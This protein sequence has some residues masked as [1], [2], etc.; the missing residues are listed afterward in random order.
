MFM[1]SMPGK[2]PVGV[3]DLVTAY[4]LLLH[5]L[6]DFR[7]GL[8]QDNFCKVTFRRLRIDPV[9]RGFAEFNQQV[10]LMSFDLAQ[11]CLHVLVW[12]KTHKTGLQERMLSVVNFRRVLQNANG[13]GVAIV[14]ESERQA[15]HQSNWQYQV[16]R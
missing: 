4:L 8:Q 12:H 6:A 16:P 2:Q 7:A 11:R 9:A 13:I 1:P 15:E 14:A 3:T 5:P 10:E